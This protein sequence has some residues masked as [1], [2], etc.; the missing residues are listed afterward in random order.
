VRHESQLDRTLWTIVLTIAVVVV[1]VS[2]ARQPLLGGGG[3]AS[4]FGTPVTLWL[5]GPQADGQVETVAQQAAA[6]WAGNGHAVTV[7][8]LPGSST[9]A[10]AGFLDSAGRTSADL[11]LLTSSTLSD[12]ARD[13]TAPPASEAGEEARHAVRLLTQASPVAILSRDRLA[14]AIRA[15]SPIHTTSELLSLI[16]REPSRPLL[17]VAEDSWEQGNLAALA[18]SANLHG[19]IPYSAFR[20]SR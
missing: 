1:A 13:S 12:I 3:E 8:V 11:L 5:P 19:E 6:C 18:Q 17:G 20:S 16:R 14:L 15:D 2:F 7:G 4:G 9:S 10:V